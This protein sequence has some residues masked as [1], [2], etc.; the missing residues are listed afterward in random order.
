MQPT[1][2]RDLAAL[3]KPRITA[4]AIMTALAGLALAPGD[5]ADA[6]WIAL[7]LG[8]ALIVGAANTLNM[9]LEREVDGLMARTRTD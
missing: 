3:A 7:V 5:A 1:T 2:A 6:P 4:F 9:Y 8:T